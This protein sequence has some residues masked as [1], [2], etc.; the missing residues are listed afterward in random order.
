MIYDVKYLRVQSRF[1]N[2]TA[3]VKQ[4]NVWKMLDPP[5]QLTERQHLLVEQMTNL[6][7]FDLAKTARA[8]YITKGG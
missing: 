4:V 2:R 3:E 1:V 5:F 7:S 6:V 8:I